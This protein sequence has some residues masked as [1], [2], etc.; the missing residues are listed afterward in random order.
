MSPLSFQTTHNSILATT[1]DETGLWVLQHDNYISWKS[2]SR[3]ALLWV[4][5]KHGSGKSHL[6]ARVI[7]ELRSIC[8]ER[9]ATTDKSN[10]NGRGE[11][12]TLTRIADTEG[13]FIIGSAEDESALFL[14]QE[15]TVSTDSS[16]NNA[17][18]SLPE[19]ADQRSINLKAHTQSAPNRTALAYV[20]CSYQQVQSSER[21]SAGRSTEPA[22][23]YDSTGILS[24]L[25]KQLYQFLPGEMDVSELTQACFETGEDRPSREAITAGIIKVVPMFSQSFIVVDGLDECNGMSSLEFE[26]FCNFLVSLTSISMTGSSAN[27]LIFSRPGYQPITNSTDGCPRIEVDKGANTEDISRFID[28]RSEHLT[29]DFASL[30]EIQGHL[31]DSAD[32]MFLWVS[33]VID[34]IKQE[35]T[36]KKMKAAARN[37][38]RGLHGAYTDAMRRIIAAEPSIKDMALKA[39]L[40]T[41]NSKRPLSRVQLLEALA[42]EEG[43]TSIGEDEKFDDGVPLTKDCADLLVVKDGQYMLLHPSLGDFLRNICDNG[44]EG[45]EA[46]QDLQTNEAHILGVDCLT[47]LNFDAFRTGPMPTEAALKEMFDRNPFLE[48][49]AVFWGDHLRDALDLHSPNLEDK[50]FGLLDSQRH[51]DIIHQVYMRFSNQRNES[52]SI[53]PFPCGTPPL[54]ILSIFGLHHLLWHY[55]ITEID[56]DEADGFGNCP[57]DYAS[58]NGHKVMSMKIVEEHKSRINGASRE[59][60]RQCKSQSWLMGTVIHQHWTDIMIMLLD[61]GHSTDRQDTGIAPNALHLASDRGY[62]DMMER[63][64]LSGSHPD[65]R[66]HNGDTPLMLATRSNHLGAAQLLL[67]HGAN[68]QYCNHKG[69]TS[70]HLA[71]GLI[72]CSEELAAILLDRGGYMEAKTQEGET[73]LHRAAAFGSESM[74]SFL[75]DRGANKHAV[76][77]GSNCTPLFLAAICDRKDAVRLLLS[78][79]ASV[80]VV[81]WRNSTALHEA[82]ALDRVEAICQILAIC[83]GRTVLDWRDNQ[84]YTAL[85]AA[86]SMGS[87]A[88]AKRLLDEGADVESANDSG[89]TPFL[90]SVDKGHTSLARMLVDIYRANPHHIDHRRLNAMHTSAAR[91]SAEDIQML[92]SW[93]IEAF[94][95]DENGR[96]P[97]HHAVLAKNATVV[98]CYVKK[99]APQ[100]TL[101]RQKDSDPLGTFLITRDLACGWSGEGSALTWRRR[102]YPPFSITK[103]F[104]WY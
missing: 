104:I 19:V 5:G 3:E 81:S 83:D 70:L 15:S 23:C 103:S 30:K 39:L 48:Y 37:M 58:K 99:F 72:D 65:V 13:D 18:N 31:L 80:H 55:P 1:L 101:L 79:G 74:I 66:D 77:R 33:L 7:E 60:S 50:T 32:G 100:S 61:L 57:L 16:D 59:I 10:E 56:I 68:V 88:S 96:T 97:L 75:L 44:V 54:H 25:L 92:L 64:L 29:K 35:R 40:W 4:Y 94:A 51:R 43:M 9:N 2:K 45:L 20:Y 28:D 41:T 17:W 27:V 26:T 85:S 34:S 67:H 53:F 36:A 98:E 42:I 71:T 62:T 24:C 78:R 84:G 52:F 82:A 21:L 8:Q 76:T 102:T 69:F 47:Y 49:A 14:W 87:I 22:D 73:P 95:R 86:A 63:L 89:M 11:G 90:I 38:P 6:T 12:S 93:G 91:G 46:Y